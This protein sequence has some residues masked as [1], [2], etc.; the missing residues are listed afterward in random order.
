V[1]CSIQRAT[2]Y[3]CAGPQ[4]SVLR[5]RRSSVPCSRSSG[6]LGIHY[7]RMSMY[8]CKVWPYTSNVKVSVRWP[9]YRLASGEGSRHLL[10]MF[11]S[12]WRSLGSRPAFAV[13]AISALALGIGLSTAVF[14]VGDAML[15]RRL[16]IRDQ[17]RVVVL[18]GKK[19]NEAF[20]YP[21]NAN[22][23]RAFAQRTRTLTRVSSFA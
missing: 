21:L 12:A 23:A 15:L 8:R 19:P 2:A 3:P 4:D 10:L 17:D 13:T 9:R 14:T 20:A 1:S 5:M 6:G 16:P 11:R 7:H 18:W 22:D